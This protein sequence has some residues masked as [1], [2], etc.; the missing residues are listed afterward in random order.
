M[1][2]TS[3]KLKSSTVVLLAIALLSAGGIYLWDRSHS[4]Q[5]QT[6]DAKKDAKPLFTLK[7]ADITQLTIQAKRQTLKLEKTGKV[8]QLKE[9]KT[10]PADEGTV[11]FLLNLLATGTSERTLQVEPAQLK[12]FGLDQPTATVSFQLQNQKTHQL[13]LGKQTFNQ[14]SVYAQIDPGSATAAKKIDV[15]LIPTGLLD[16]ISRPL[17][18][19]QAKPNL[20]KL[21]SPTQPPKQP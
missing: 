21:L 4:E 19:W 2:E 15:V 5:S 1:V 14:S 20:P 18:E 16:A 13:V 6:A 8:W 17:S 3:M 9:P 11:A 7:E 12:E 10:G